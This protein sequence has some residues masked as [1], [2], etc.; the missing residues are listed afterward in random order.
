[1]IEVSLSKSVRLISPRLTVLVNTLDEKG[2][3]TSSPYSWVFPLS[4]N[5]PLIGVGIGSKQKLSFVNSKIIHIFFTSV[6]YIIN[7]ECAE[8]KYSF[9]SQFL[10]G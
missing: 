7:A 3:L 6:C 4:L 9:S 2:E 8:D 5:P 1:M 10:I